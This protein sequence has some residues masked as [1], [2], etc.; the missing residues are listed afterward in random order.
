MLLKIQ[1]YKG[2]YVSFL[3][4]SSMFVY[5]YAFMS[6][7]MYVFIHSLIHFT[8]GSFLYKH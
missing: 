7:C 3:E 6:V 8:N 5:M 2:T 1:K 4:T